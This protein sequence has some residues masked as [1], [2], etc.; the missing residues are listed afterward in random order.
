MSMISS[1]RMKTFALAILVAG[2]AALLVAPP[3]HAAV[4]VTLTGAAAIPTGSEPAVCS[5]NDVSVGVQATS[6]ATYDNNSSSNG[7]ATCLNCNNAAVP[8]EISCSGNHVL[9]TP[10]T[11]VTITD[12][13]QTVSAND[14]SFGH[15]TN[16]TSGTP[17]TGSLGVP[18]TGN[19]G[20]I[21]VNFT[22][23]ASEK[24]TQKNQHVYEYYSGNNCVSGPSGTQYVVTDSTDV[25]YPAATQQT[26]SATYLLDLDPPTVTHD[27]DTHSVSQSGGVVN[28]NIYM[29][30]GSDSA[31][32]GAT[33][34]AS[35]INVSSN[36]SAGPDTDNF[37][38]SPTS[39]GIAPNKTE[40]V[41][42]EVNC[43]ALPDDYSTDAKVDTDDLCGDAFSTVHSSSLNDLDHQFT[44]T[45]DAS[46]SSV[47]NDAVVTAPLPDVPQDPNGATG[48]TTVEC[49][50][51][52]QTGHG[53]NPNKL[54]AYP[55]TLHVGV[56][57]M[58]GE[59][60]G[61]CTDT[62]NAT[63]IGFTL[64]DDFD[65]LL[66]GRSPA[67]HL[68]FGDGSGG[69]AYHS[70]LPLVGIDPLLPESA[71]NIADKVMTIDL[72]GLDVG[73]GA[74]K[75]PKGRTLYARAHVKMTDGVETDEQEDFI[76]H[77]S[78][79]G[80]STDDTWSVI[81]NPTTTQTCVD[82]QLVPVD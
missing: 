7:T 34:L 47:T 40:A 67:V 24:R 53:K 45:A 68:F 77:V 21:T 37:G 32:Y 1:L 17:W 25:T 41:A 79:G 55:G 42:L 4:S 3:A 74:G 9:S 72:T 31:A 14:G 16:L 82:G 69:F 78:I 11:V 75:L 57:V 62:L 56:V 58:T 65:Y 33:A 48:Y 19:D 63:S 76:S 29:E 61:T 6:T 28:Y 60:D 23:D 18:G 10:R 36:L 12:K 50:T 52:H 13:T 54:V 71:I 46:C 43:S 5:A 49:Y 2:A 8:S 80:G 20:K 51:S 70:G 81:E 35:A 26:A 15:S 59:G 27:I 39:N 64:P 73:C 30:G 44:V 38:V 22:A 66:T